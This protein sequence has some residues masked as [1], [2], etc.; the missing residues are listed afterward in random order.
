M[1][2]RDTDVLITGVGV[3]CALGRGRGAVTQGWTRGIHG[4]TPVPLFGI[5]PPDPLPCGVVPREVTG[6]VAPPCRAARLLEMALE[7]T[8][9]DAALTPPA[10]TLLIAGTSSGNVQ[11]LTTAHHTL[12][13]TGRL[14]LQTLS[15][16]PPAVAGVECARRYGLRP[17]TLSS[18][19]GASLCALGSGVSMIQGGETP[20][21]I[22]GGYEALSPYLV[23]GF[24]SL[25]LISA[26]LCRPFDQSHSGINPGE[27]SAFFVLE[28][29]EHARCRG[30]RP[31]AEIAGFGESIDI[32]PRGVCATPPPV[33]SLRRA[34]DNAGMRPEEIDALHL[35][36]TGTET[37]DNA[38]CLACHTVFGEHL[39]RLPA[40]ATK[41]Y[42]GHAFGASGALAT[43]FALDT[44][45]TG[46]VPPTLRFE[47]PVP[48]LPHPSFSAAPQTVPGSR[49][50]VMVIS[51]GFGGEAYALIVRKGKDS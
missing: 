16:F 4:I 41:S 36:G 26:Q 29:R 10:G 20:C 25:R 19:C 23:S 40:G 47:S 17:R 24:Y 5:T 27:G 49:R 6:A 43:V 28:S 50:A 30:A 22:A 21:V 31:L 48:D 38:E 37:N 1:V 14:D 12:R 33:A 45:A 51:L 13:T 34:L 44:V 42:T 35:H 7:D 39:A 3:V 9:A 18:A 2:S 46:M 11:A 32:P 15:R 8:L